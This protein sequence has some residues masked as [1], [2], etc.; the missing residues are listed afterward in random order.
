MP[1]CE[2]KTLSG[3]ERVRG[4]IADFSNLEEVSKMAKT[5]CRDIPKLDV[6]INNAGVFKVENTQNKDGLD[7]RM[8]VNYLAP[9]VLTNALLPLLDKSAKGRVV[10][11]SSAA[12]E[13]VEE[14]VLKGE[15]Y[16]DAHSVYAQ[17]KL[18]LTMWSFDLAKEQQEVLVIAVNP[19]SLLNTK[20]VQEAYGKHWSSADKGANILFELALSEDYRGVTGKYFN[21]DLGA[22]KGMFGEAHPDAYDEDK[23]NA[24]KT[25]TQSIVASK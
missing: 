4:L 13:S 20:M 22:D 14:A 10:N 3:N 17:S 15:E 12:Q 1:N 11:L 25:I 21:N 18:A 5:V 7:V 2:V 16:I 9:Y 23:L 8:V 19:G 6:L 24:L